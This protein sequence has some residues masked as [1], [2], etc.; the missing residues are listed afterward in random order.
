MRTSYLSCCYDYK[1]VFT[2]HYIDLSHVR[3]NYL[4]PMKRHPIYD[5]NT[6]C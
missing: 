5:I 2:T 3:V 4:A 1:D 6:N